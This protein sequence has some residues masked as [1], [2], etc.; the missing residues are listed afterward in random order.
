MSSVAIWELDANDPDQDCAFRFRGRVTDAKPTREE[1]K[2]ICAPGRRAKGMVPVLQRMCRH[3]VYFG[4]CGLDREDWFTAAT[5]TAIDGRVV[6]I[7]AAAAYADGALQFGL[8]EHGAGLFT[9]AANSGASVRLL[10]NTPDLE[11]AIAL[12]GSAAVRLARGCNRL[13]PVCDGVFDNS[14]NFGG[15]PTMKDSP[16]DGRSLL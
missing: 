16:F 2:L 7:P 8:L 13:M 11:A 5:A 6:T 10:D 12:S 1:T 14:L 4:G 9:I 3:S 15:V